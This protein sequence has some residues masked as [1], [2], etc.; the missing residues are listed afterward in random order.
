ME[1]IPQIKLPLWECLRRSFSYVLANFDAFVKIASVWFLVLIYEAVAGFPSLCGIREG[2][3]PSE[4]LQNLSVVVISL[5]SIAIAVG[6]C[7]HIIL[8]EKVNYLHFSFGRRELKYLAYSLFLFLLI[9]IPSALIIGILANILKY[10]GVNIPG[11]S[12]IFILLPIIIAVICARFF[13]I[14]PAIAVDDKDISLKV[15]FALT[16]GNANKIFWGQ[17]LMMLPVI[18][19]LTILSSLYDAMGLGGFVADFIMAALVLGF[20]FLD[21]ALKAAYF[22]HIYQY[23]VYFWKHSED[24]VK[25]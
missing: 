15:A 16:K 21:T 5:A 23:F 24:L 12:V 3:C 13:I 17:A 11:T 18:I 14:L 6:F 20:S 19:I 9:I 22:S 7:R 8:K 4:S 25:A 2:A 1:T 10:V